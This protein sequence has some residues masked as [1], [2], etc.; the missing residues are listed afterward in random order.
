VR[1]VVEKVPLL[2]DIPVLGLLFRYETRQ[3]AKTNLVVFLRPVVLRDAV[4]YSRMSAERYR[5]MLDEQ[6]ASKPPA[7]PVLPEYPPPELPPLG[8]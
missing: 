7:N 5:N 8:D 6:K 1:V 4:T 3:Q 2:G